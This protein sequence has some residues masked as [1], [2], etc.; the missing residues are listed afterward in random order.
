MKQFKHFILTRFN[1]MYMTDHMLY[2]DKKKADDWMKGRM[3]LF[4]KTKKSVLSQDGEFTWVI[5]VDKRTPKKFL[6]KI[7]G[8]GIIIT[9][10]DIRNI[11]LSGE[12]ISDAPWTITTRL[13]ND[14]VYVEGAINRI[15]SR[16]EPLLKVIDVNFKKLDTESGKYH[17]SVWKWQNSPFISLVEPSDRVLTAFCRPHGQVANGYPSGK[18]TGTYPAGKVLIEI[19]MERIEDVC[20]IQV[21]HDNNLANKI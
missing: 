21:C 20:A 7:Q 14:D 1:T 5:S 4:E 15:Q 8:E 13:D 18:L 3:K 12:V 10:D 2:D 19:K 6:D 17:P 11:F 9:N 16:F